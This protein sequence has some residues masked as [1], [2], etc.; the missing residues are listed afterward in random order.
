MQVLQLVGRRAGEVLEMPY[1]VALRCIEA[2]TARPYPEVRVAPQAAPVAA[3][4][5]I[6]DP[7]PVVVA[8]RRPGRPRKHPL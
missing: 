3:L 4:E 2:Q 6:D 5:P 7:L 1:A 8:K